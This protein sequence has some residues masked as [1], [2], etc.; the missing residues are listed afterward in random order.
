MDIQHYNYTYS[1]TV[2]QVIFTFSYFTPKRRII[3]L[4]IFDSLVAA[5]LHS[6]HPR[7]KLAELS[8]YYFNRPDGIGAIAQNIGNLSTILLRRRISGRRDKQLSLERCGECVAA[9]L[10]REGTSPYSQPCRSFRIRKTYSP[11]SSSSPLSGS[12]PNQW[13]ESA[14]FEIIHNLVQIIAFKDGAY[15]HPIELVFIFFI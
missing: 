1:D 15:L 7:T 12:S 3:S 14:A 4:I 11:I 2:Y 10:I 8:E 6:A 5:S 9:V 13:S